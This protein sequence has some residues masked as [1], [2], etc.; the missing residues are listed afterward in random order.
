MGPQ[1][2]RGFPGHKGERGQTGQNG[3][4]GDRVSNTEFFLELNMNCEYE[5][6]QVFHTYTGHIYNSCLTYEVISTLCQ[7]QAA[8]RNNKIL[9]FGTFL[10]FSKRDVV[11]F[12][13]GSI[14]FANSCQNLWNSSRASTNI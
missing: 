12:Y 14:A 8:T 10:A 2:E 13:F 1:G 6:Q 9:Y 3:A 5:F 11:H 7:C 4:K